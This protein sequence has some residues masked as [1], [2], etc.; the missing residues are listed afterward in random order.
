MADIKSEQEYQNLIKD[1]YLI[2][3]F[4]DYCDLSNYFINHLEKINFKNIFLVDR[5]KNNILF[6]KLFFLSTPTI[7]F[8]KKIIFPGDT[9]SLNH[10]IE[11]TQ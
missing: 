9:N 2:I 1:N 3:V 7:I 4:E 11:H 8:N 6:N 10:I 5:K